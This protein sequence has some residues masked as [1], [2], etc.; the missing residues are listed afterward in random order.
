MKEALLQE[1]FSQTGSGDIRVLRC[2]ALE[3]NSLTSD[4]SD[5]REIVRS[6]PCVQ[7]A[8]LEELILRRNSECDFDGVSLN[9]QFLTGNPS[10]LDELQSI[11]KKLYG[12]ILPIEMDGKSIGYS[13]STTSSLALN[14]I[15]E[16][17]TNNAIDVSIRRF[18]ALDEKVNPRMRDG[19]VMLVEKVVLPEND[20]LNLSDNSLFKIIVNDLNVI[21]L[22]CFFSNKLSED[23]LENDSFIQGLIENGNKVYLYKPD[24]EEILQ[25]YV[26]KAE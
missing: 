25:V 7:K 18:I 13:V 17:Y 24:G 10:V 12:Q 16:L 8:L 5:V 2:E 6:H 14:V 1:V 4:I 22:A 23:E 19:S 26:K 15:Q 3:N 9:Y 21:G 20:R 11:L